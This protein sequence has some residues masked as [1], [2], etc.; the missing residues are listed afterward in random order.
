M[1]QSR[2]L[3]FQESKTIKAIKIEKGDFTIINKDQHFRK[4]F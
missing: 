2:I 3:Q 4:Y 1:L